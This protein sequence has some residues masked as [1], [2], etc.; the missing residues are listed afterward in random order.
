M[1]GYKKPYLALFVLVVLG[2]GLPLA[3]LGADASLAQS[4]EAW[5]PVEVLVG[6]LAL[7]HSGADLLLEL[8][9][10]ARMVTVSGVPALERRK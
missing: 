7:D 6:D 2:L 5:I 4:V 3:N 9:V 8:G 10:F 1:N